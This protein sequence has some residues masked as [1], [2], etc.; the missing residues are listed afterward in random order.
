MALTCNYCDG[1]PVACATVNVGEKPADPRKL[2]TKQDPRK[3]TI[4]RA[5]AEHVDRLPKS[6]AVR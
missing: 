6:E 3:V 1:R 4:V 5:C 2:C